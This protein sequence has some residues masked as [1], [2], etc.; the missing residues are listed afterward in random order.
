[1]GDATIGLSLRANG[2]GLLHRS[3][4]SGAPRVKGEES[5]QGRPTPPMA[6]VRVVECRMLLG[7]S[8]RPIA[9]VLRRPPGRGIGREASDRAWRGERVPC[10]AGAGES[11]DKKVW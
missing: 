2:P 10:R 8:P 11:D 7:D 1:M 5:I 9:V 3:R 6:R 4:A